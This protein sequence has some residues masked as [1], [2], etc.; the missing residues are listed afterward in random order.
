MRWMV[1]L[2]CL[3][4]CGSSPESPLH[5]WMQDNGKVKILSTTAMIDDLVGQIGGD[6]VDHLVLITGEMDPHSYEMVKGDEEKFSCASLIFF[7]G[8]GFE[9][10]ASLRAQ[11]QNHPHA[12][13]LGNDSSDVRSFTSRRTDRSSRMDGYLALGPNDPGDRR[14]FIS[15]RPERG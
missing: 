11:L 10:G 9:H 8:L 14:Q 13:A 12:I 5:R 2:L 6:R 3:F 4:G 15:K 7:N 1:L